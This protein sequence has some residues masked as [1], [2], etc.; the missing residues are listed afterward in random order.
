M[1]ADFAQYALRGL[2]LG[3]VFALL[4]VGLV[5]NYKTSGVFNLASAAQGYASA[6]VFFELRKEHEWAL[7]PAA[8]VAIVVVGV[9][10]ALFLDVAIYRHQRTASPLAKL[11]TS[12]GLLVAIPQVVLLVIGTETKLNPPPLWPVRRVDDLLWPRDSAYAL[13]AG[14]IS[15]LLATSVVVLALILLFGRTALGL[16]MRAVVESPRLLQLQGIDASRVALG[17]TLLSSLLA[18]LAGVLIAPLFAQ[19]KALDFFALLIAAI[20]AAVAAR[21]SSISIAV[22]AGLGLG[23]LQAELAGFLPTDSVL[24]T[25]LRPSLPFV[26]LFVLLLALRAL[27]TGRSVSDPMAGVEPPPVSPAAG[28]LGTRL[29][30]GTTALLAVGA[31][32][33]A[34]AVAGLLLDDLWLGLVAGGVGL[35]VVMLSIVLTVGVGQTISLCQGTFAAIGAFT[36]AQLTQHDWP[37]MIAIVAGAVVAATAAAVLAYP[38]LRLPGIYAALATLA[39]ALM[40]E[41]V[42][43]PLG[44]VSG[45]PQPL[46]VPRPVI[47]GWHVTTNLSFLLL[48]SGCLAVLGLAVVAIR[49]GT[50]GRFLDAHGGSTAGAAAVGINATRHRFVVFVLGGAVAGVGGGLIASYAGFANYQQSFTF[51]FS[52]V[53]V[54]IVVT[55]GAR[56]V[57]AATVAGVMFFVFPEILG[58]LFAWPG[59]YLA[60]HPETSGWARSALDAVDPSWAGGVAFVLFGLGALSFA[61]HPEGVLQ[62]QLGGLAQRLRARGEHRGGTAAPPASGERSGRRAPALGGVR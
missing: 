20:A 37:V 40:F 35:S 27:R 36:T 6:A 1:I 31:A 55:L 48:A 33:V 24:A 52:L 46:R 62:S 7:L 23:V 28:E 19:L 43:V 15:T 30:A 16:R 11:V 9:G 29:G 21:L 44:W 45:G 34:L 4:A 59:N 18:S 14:Q 32:G 12:L 49:R 38:V 53:W 51:F 2:P 47:L 50:T 8:L 58:R 13:D 41:G 54:A 25:G 22:V 60:S 17:S 61:R 57:A 42:L 3:C 26:V 10:L 5:L 39:F 56:S